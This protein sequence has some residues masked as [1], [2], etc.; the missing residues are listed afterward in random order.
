MAIL[1]TADVPGQT[2]EGY[3]GLLAALRE[4]LEQAKG[5]IAH[6]GAPSDNG[7]TVMELWETETDAHQFFATYVHP[8]LPAGIK[9]RRSFVELH[10]L[11]QR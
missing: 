10:S 5:F 6:Y 4:T 11:I 1:M 9:P 8:I 2:Q 3:D 7:W